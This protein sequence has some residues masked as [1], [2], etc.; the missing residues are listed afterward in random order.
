MWAVL[1]SSPE[2]S[3]SDDKKVRAIEALEEFPQILDQV[4]GKASDGRAHG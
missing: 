3:L 1:L 4:M 2:V